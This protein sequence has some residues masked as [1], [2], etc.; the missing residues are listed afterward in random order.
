[1]VAQVSEDAPNGSIVALPLQPF[2]AANEKFP[3]EN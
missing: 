3:E 1:V 2:S